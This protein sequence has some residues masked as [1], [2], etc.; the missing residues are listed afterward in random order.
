MISDVRPMPLHSTAEALVG[1][2]CAL[3]LHRL[4]GENLH[5]L[6]PAPTRHHGLIQPGSF[7]TVPLLRWDVRR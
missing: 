6:P 5:A 1:G 4:P 2:R 3:R 7:P